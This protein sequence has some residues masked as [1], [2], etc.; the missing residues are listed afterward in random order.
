MGISMGGMVAQELALQHPDRVAALVLG[1]TTPGSDRAAGVEEL[2]EKIAAFHEMGDGSPD[3]VWFA[4]FLKHLWTDEA[5]VKSDE[6]LQDFVFSI[7][8]YPPT[9]H[10]LRGQADA[11]AAHD[12]FERL[13]EIRHPTLVMT[14]DEDSLIDPGNSEI[15]AER[16]PDAGLL[17]Y[18]GLKHAFHLERPDLINP[19]VIEFI[20][21]F[22]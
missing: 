10:G 1:C 4:D 22:G 3:L 8:R 6:Y 12:T 2:S 20:E 19:K 13:S 18:K 9:G 7:I 15:L 11:V 21:R 5:L 16:I 17:V 14:G